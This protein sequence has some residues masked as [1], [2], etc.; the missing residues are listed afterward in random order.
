METHPEDV[1]D[2]RLDCPWPELSR[3][4][5]TLNLSEMDDF[6]HG[7]VPYILILLKFLEQWKQTVP[8]PL[9]VMLT[10][11][12]NSPPTM[13]DRKLLNEMLLK[14]KRNIDEENIDEAV[15]A[16][17]R[18]CRKTEIPAPI[19]QILH[20]PKAQNLTSESSNFWILA[21]CV[22]DF[23]ADSEGGNGMLPLMG[24]VP[25]MKADSNRYILIQN[26][27]FFP[28][29]NVLINYSY[30]RKFRADLENMSHRVKVILKELGREQGEISQ[31]EIEAFCKHAGY[32]K[33]M[34]YRSLE[35]EYI[36][37]RIKFIRNRLLR[38]TRLIVEG[39][40]ENTFPP[41]LIHY[42]LA[43]RA[44]DRFLQVYSQPPGQS[45]NVQ[46]DVSIMTSFVRDILNEEP[47]HPEMVANACAEMFSPFIRTEG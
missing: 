7:H 17:F 31:D 23:V 36:S 37:A 10:E 3:L 25:D 20:D 13:K 2:L 44:Y 24:V 22:A 26:W 12:H 21:K 35:E 34:R 38:L 47:L 41:T 40:F 29:L 5:N 33:V 15:A 45:E 43:L 39:E 46:D 8:P 1:V 30:R 6:E 32:L 27:L 42:Y 9:Y 14:E 28:S 19:Q 4:A 11:K 16:S 18:A